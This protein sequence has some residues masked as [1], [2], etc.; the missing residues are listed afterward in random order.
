MAGQY[1]RRSRELVAPALGVRQFKFSDDQEQPLILVPTLYKAEVS[2]TYRRLWIQNQR[3]SSWAGVQIQETINYA[4]GLA[5]T[6]WVMNTLTLH[7]SYQADFRLNDANHIITDVSLPVLSA[8]SRLPYS[9][10]VSKPEMSNASAFLKETSLESL[11][12]YINP[13]LSVAYRF[14]I[15]KRLGLQA[16]YKY[17]WLHY[18]EPRQIRSASHTGNLSLIYQYHFQYK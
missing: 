17:Q 9:N 5:M 18:T 4:D 6:T 8:V 15:S 2:L 14:N 16:S 12:R 13:Q 11:N 3:W 7:L 10:A 1:Q